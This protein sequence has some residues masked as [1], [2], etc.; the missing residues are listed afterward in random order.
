MNLKHILKQKQKNSKTEIGGHAK[1][2]HNFSLWDAGFYGFDLH[3][4]TVFNLNLFF[5]PSH[6][7]FLTV[8]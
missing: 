2:K 8:F 5:P 6:T 4:L 3:V 1:N 7:V